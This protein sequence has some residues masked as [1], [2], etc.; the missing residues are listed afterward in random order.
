MFRYLKLFFALFR[1]SLTRELM[2]KANFILWVVVEFAWFG[3]QLAL[4]EVIF[5]HV[6]EVAGWNKY[7][8]ILLIGTSHFI[9]QVFQFV[10]LINC[11]ELPDQVRTGKLDFLLLQPA[12]SQ[13]LV[14]IRKFDLGTLV[15]SSIGLSFVIYAAWKLNLKPT[16]TQIGLFAALVFNGVFIHYALMLAVVTLSFWIVRTQGLVYGYYNLFQITRIPREAF[17]GSIKFIFTF[18]LPMLVVANYPAGVL[19]RGVQGSGILWVFVLT[20]ALVF[21]ASLWFR[22]ALRFY[23]SASS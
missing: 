20:A 5:A 12:N 14:S 3:I 4:V 15:N 6:S 17:K 19:A 23:T 7:E 16:F 18:V 21:L 1:Y 10:F 11:V 13:F 2:F 22:F 9:Q 8:M